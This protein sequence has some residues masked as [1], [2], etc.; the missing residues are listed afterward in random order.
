MFAPEVGRE[1]AKKGG[2]EGR[3]QRGKVGGVDESLSTF[4]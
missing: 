3:R 2:K 1:D 4:M